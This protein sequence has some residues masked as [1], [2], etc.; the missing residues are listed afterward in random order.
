MK[1]NLQNH[2]KQSLNQKIY[3]EKEEED[4]IQKMTLSDFIRYFLS[5]HVIGVTE[6]TIKKMQAGKGQVIVPFNFMPSD[7]I[8]AHLQKILY[9]QNDLDQSAKSPKNKNNRQTI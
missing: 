9:K 5:E 8:Y 7:F 4:D 2:K 3:R 1:L 6:M